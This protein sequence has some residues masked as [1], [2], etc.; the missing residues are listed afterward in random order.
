MVELIPLVH[1]WI[2]SSNAPLYELK[3]PAEA[4]DSEVESLCAARED[5]A[6]HATYRVAWVVD[7]S[8]VLSAN[9]YQRSVFS[10]HLKRFEPHDIAYN[11]GSALIVPNAFVRGLVTAVFWVRP[12][13]FPNQFFAD[14]ASARGWARQRLF[15]DT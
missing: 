9:A 3:F 1:P 15:P 4:N 5:W 13:R 2:D 12:P 7:L 8:K 10:A 6:K 11:Q 14:A